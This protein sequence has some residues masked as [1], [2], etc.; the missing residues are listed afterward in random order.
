VI[1]EAQGIDNPLR[2]RLFTLKEAAVYLGRGEWG[3]RELAWSGEIPVVKKEKDH[4]LYF[5]DYDLNSYID[6][7]KTVY[8]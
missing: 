7:S 1:G 6:R 5:D 8:R 4:K 3:M 2:K